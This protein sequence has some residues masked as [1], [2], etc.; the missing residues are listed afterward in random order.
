MKRFFILS[1]LFWMFACHPEI[2][3]I[4]SKEPG[5]ISG[6]VV[7]IDVVATV[8]LYQGS[9]V[10]ETNTDADGIFEFDDVDPG[11]YR[12]IARAENYGSVELSGIKVSDSE[13][14]DTGI[15]EL[16]LYPAPL[17][18]SYPYNGARDISISNAYIRLYFES[19]ML[20]ESIEKAFSITPEL[21][22]LSFSHPTYYSSGNR[23]SYIIEGD[24][25]PG[26]E[27]TYTIDTNAVSYTGERLEFSF[28]SSFTTEKFKITSIIC[29][30]GS[31][32]VLTI[33]FNCS[34]SADN[35]DK[36]SIN[37][38]TP[39]YLDDYYS[40]NARGTDSFTYFRI[41][42]E[43]SWMTDTIYTVLISSEITESGGTTLGRDSTFT[44]VT[45]PLEIADTYPRNE[46]CYISLLPD[47]MVRFNNIVDESTIA[48]ALSVSPEAV[49]EIWT[50]YSDGYNYFYLNV[51]EAL[52][53][54]TEYVVAIST[55]LQD[56]Y[57]RHLENPY[58]FRFVTQ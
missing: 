30:G 5:M 45:D 8:E 16:S 41:Y 3:V 22:N 42:P 32:S 19:Y 39:A 51:T 58:S 28:S 17:I 14:Y 33:S 36:I 40:L 43:I 15:I 46:Q 48:D 57:G 7:P 26:I 20:P 55:A 23:Y 4:I 49:Y 13:G 52:Q 10:A 1:L 25:K 53:R 34:V 24:F 6:I 11:T 12:I 50:Y 9:L 31:Y 35:F 29:N 38:P 27:Y 21:E 37:P 56:Y 2:N 47:I 44:F 18:D 54:K